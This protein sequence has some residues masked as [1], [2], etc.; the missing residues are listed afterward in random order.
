MLCVAF[1]FSQLSTIK[2]AV[3]NKKNLYLVEDI[4]FIKSNLAMLWN[5]LLQFEHFIH[6]VESVTRIIYA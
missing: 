3:I 5:N 4:D 2:I 6:H 1:L